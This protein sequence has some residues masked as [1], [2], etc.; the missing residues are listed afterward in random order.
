MVYLADPDSGLFT[1][2][3]GKILFCTN[4]HGLCFFGGKEEGMEGGGGVGGWAGG[5]GRGFGFFP[6][7]SPE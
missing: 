3:V 2:T 7:I 1:L 5:G 6:F 4:Y